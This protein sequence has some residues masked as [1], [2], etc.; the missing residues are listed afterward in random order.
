MRVVHNDTFSYPNKITF[1]V[2]FFSRFVHE[3]T[4]WQISHTKQRVYAILEDSNQKKQKADAAFMPKVG[5]K[6]AR[7][8]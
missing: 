7:K 6:I 2:D 8:W 4:N 1:G 5:L 3:D